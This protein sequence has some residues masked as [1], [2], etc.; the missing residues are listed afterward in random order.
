MGLGYD[1]MSSTST[2]RSHEIITYLTLNRYLGH[3]DVK[4]GKT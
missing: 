3:G 4:D 2:R 1:H